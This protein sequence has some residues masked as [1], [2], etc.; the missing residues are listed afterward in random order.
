MAVCNCSGVQRFWHSCL[1]SSSED[2]RAL[3]YSERVMI[4]LL[5]RAMISSTV[6]PEAVGVAGFFAGARAVAGGAL[7]GFSGVGATTGLFGV[8]CDLSCAASG[9]AAHSAA[10]TAILLIHSLIWPV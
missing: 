6:L 2:W 1:T 8:S 4:S 9:R 7:P 5:T 10:M 3:L